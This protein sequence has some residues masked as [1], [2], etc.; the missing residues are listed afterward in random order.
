MPATMA[1]LHRRRA[2]EIVDQQGDPLAGCNG[3]SADDRR[4]QR[5][6]RASAGSSGPRR[7]PGSPW[8]PRPSSISASPSSKPG[9]PAAGTV[10]GVSATPIVPSGGRVAGLGG[11]LG[12]ARARLGR[13]AGDLVDEHRAGQAATA[14]VLAAAGQRDVVGHD[15]HLDRNPFGSRDSAAR[16]K[17]SRSPV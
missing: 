17:L 7:T 15:H 10:Q 13:R 16:P 1:Q 9:L 5:S 3:Q 8:M 14:R 2:A 4:Q 11:D 6:T 12:Q